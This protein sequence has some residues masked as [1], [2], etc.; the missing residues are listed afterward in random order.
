MN[1]MKPDRN[2]NH[3]EAL[4]SR[5]G[6]KPL[7]ITMPAPNAQVDPLM[8]DILAGHCRAIAAA[9][10]VLTRASRPISPKSSTSAPTDSTV[11]N[12]FRRE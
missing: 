11:K 1:T 6:V 4:M 8:A 12:S 7:D 10:F 9:A 2:D 5:R 3:A